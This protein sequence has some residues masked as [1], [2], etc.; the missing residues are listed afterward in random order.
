MY[1]LNEESFK[2][3]ALGGAQIFQGKQKKTEERKKTPSRVINKL[4]NHFIYPYIYESSSRSLFKFTDH[5][6]SSLIG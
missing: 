2:S 4:I 6:M 5:N 3:T 1:V